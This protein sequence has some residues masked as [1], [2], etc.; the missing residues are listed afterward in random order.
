M[1]TKPAKK[2]TTTTLQTRDLFGPA[3]P[4]APID[5]SGIADAI[6]HIADKVVDGID[7]DSVTDNVKNLGHLKSIADALAA[8]VIAQHGTEED[9]KRV[10]H[11]LKERF[12]S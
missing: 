6:R 1:P 11:K 2:K 3:A 9:R 5:L 7:F 8:Q 4:H 10:V 12:F